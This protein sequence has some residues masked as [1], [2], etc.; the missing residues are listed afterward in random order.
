MFDRNLMRFPG[1][2]GIMG[3]LAMLALLQAAA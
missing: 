3:A 1:M 2:G